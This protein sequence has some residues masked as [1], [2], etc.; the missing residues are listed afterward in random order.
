MGGLVKIN[1]LI[2]DCLD[3]NEGKSMLY[4]RFSLYLAR[5]CE[6]ELNI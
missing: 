5:N 3:K 4:N 2:V 1:V 6:I